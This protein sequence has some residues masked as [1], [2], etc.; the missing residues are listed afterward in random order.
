MPGWAKLARNVVGGLILLVLLILV[1]VWLWSYPPAPGKFFKAD[2]AEG[3]GPG[4]LLKS[5][6][7]KRGVPKG[8]LAQRILYTTTLNGG[9]PAT[10]SALVMWKPQEDI[11]PP[12]RVILWAH[13]TLGAAPGCGASMQANP[14][15]DVPALGALLEEGW[16]YVASDY[17]GLT[18][19]GPHPYLIGDGEAR[20]VLDAARAAH[21]L[22]ELTLSLETVIWG[23]SQGGH[24]ALWSGILAHSYAPEL[25]VKGIAAFAP[26]TDLPA[27]V[28]ETET[29]PIGRIFSSFAARAYADTY[30]DL[31]FSGIVRPEARWQAGE[32]AKRCF[33]DARI[34]V[35]LLLSEKFTEGSIFR[36]GD[37]GTSFRKKLAENI[38]NRPFGA[39][40]LILQGKRDDLVSAKMQAGFA[41]ERCAAG[42]TIDYQ[43]FDTLDHVSIV[44]PDAPTGPA[45]LKWTRARF[46]GKP[47]PKVCPK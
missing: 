14:F 45:L 33:A 7:F 3:T 41:R 23:H 26:A 25:Q 6:T 8:A 47:A 42:E 34:V 30:P 1:A 5:E 15:A 40:V 36:G 22:D 29:A 44:A 13:G 35:P 10:A 20:S 28:A 17:A 46:E 2:V 32:M 18:T 11:A 43:L 27:I 16:V 39:P 31:Y 21:E 4:H 9:E 24:A 12:Q 19:P 38:P 37:T